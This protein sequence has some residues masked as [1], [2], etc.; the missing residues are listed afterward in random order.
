MRTNASWV[1]SDDRRACQRRIRLHPPVLKA[2]RYAVTLITTLP[3]YDPAAL[4]DVETTDCVYREVEGRKLLATVYTPQG[5]G[6]F[7]L[8]IDVHGGGWANFDRL[9]DAPIDRQLASHGMVVAA[10]DFRLNGEAPHPAGMQDLNYAIRWFKAHAARFKAS[11]EGIGAIGYSSGSHQVLL[12][13]IRP[14]ESRYHAGEVEGAASVDASLSYVVSCGCIFD[15]VESLVSTFRGVVDPLDVWQY[16]GG[17]PG[18]LADSPQHII[19][20]DEAVDSVPLLIIQAG[21]D[22]IGGGRLSHAAKFAAAYGARGGWAE[23]AIAPNAGHIFLNSDLVEPTAE[24]V[25]AL[26]AIEGFI[27]RQL[28][29]LAEPFDP[30]AFAAVPRGGTR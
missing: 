17:A 13:G 14:N 18:L 28:R 23:L 26:S 3:Q 10:I 4:Y 2:E 15:L 29:Y 27:S 1:R 9:R 21:A 12:S 19:D 24:L 5:D 16:F 11:A 6:P 22:D 20:S 30:A 8:L 25:R 7:P